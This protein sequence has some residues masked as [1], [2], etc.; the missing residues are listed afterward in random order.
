MHKASNPNAFTRNL[1]GIEYHK[2]NAGDVAQNV[3][4]GLQAV[5]LFPKNL[6]NQVLFGQDVE[7]L[8]RSRHEKRMAF[9]PEGSKTYQQALD[10][11]ADEAVARHL[12]ENED[13]RLFGRLGVDDPEQ[14]EAMQIGADRAMKELFANHT[15]DET[16]LFRYQQGG[17]DGRGYVGLPVAQRYELLPADADLRAVCLKAIAE[18]IANA[19]LED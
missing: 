9:R 12:A 8:E 16:L 10:T 3:K 6:V 13:Q 14:A 7:F 2:R 4:R 17:A 18:A 1:Q 19:N 11:V 5:V 15:I